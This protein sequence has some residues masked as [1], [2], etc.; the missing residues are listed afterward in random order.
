MKA[1]SGSLAISDYEGIV[2]PAYYICKVNYNYVTKHF[3]HYYLR[4]RCLVQLYAMLSA[5]LRIG[6]W[7]LSIEDFQSI[8][9]IIPPTLKEQECIVEYIDKRCSNID[10][11]IDIKQ[12]K[13]EKLQKYKKSLI[14]E[15]VTGKKEVPENE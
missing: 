12:S 6:Q 9:I 8:E 13:I 14:Y 7:D 11:I 5:G 1:W 4:N 2:S 15:Y 3:I 10:R